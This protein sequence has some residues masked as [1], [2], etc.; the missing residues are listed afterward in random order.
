MTLTDAQEMHRQNPTTFE[1]PSTEELAA[2][3]VGYFAK[4]CADPE[5]FWVRVTGRTGSTLYGIIDND[6]LRSETHGLHCG[7]LVEFE[8]RHIYAIQLP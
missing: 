6:L 8:E 5:R 3:N 4:V 7:E 1:V 2:V